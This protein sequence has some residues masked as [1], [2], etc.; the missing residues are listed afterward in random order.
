[1]N[2]RV[3]DGV[4]QSAGG[5]NQGDG[6]MGEAVKLVQAAGLEEAR[7]VPHQMAF[8]AAL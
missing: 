1:L 3:D 8:V 5:V 7:H 6:P 2:V 4:D